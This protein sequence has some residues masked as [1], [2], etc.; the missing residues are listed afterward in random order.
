[1]NLL[2]SI[3]LYRIARRVLAARDDSSNRLH[4]VFRGDAV[5]FTTVPSDLV[6]GSVVGITDVAFGLAIVDH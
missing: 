2:I 6:V 4:A 1:M 3:W 5:A